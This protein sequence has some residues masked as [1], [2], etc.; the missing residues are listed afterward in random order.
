[1]VLQKNISIFNKFC[2]NIKPF[3]VSNKINILPCLNI[4]Y[5]HNDNLNNL[6][7]LKE[8]MHNKNLSYVDIDINN[9]WK[10]KHNFN[11]TNYMIFDFDK[12]NNI[13]DNYFE[14][15]ILY[16]IFKNIGGIIYL[17][18]NINVNQYMYTLSHYIFINNQKT[19]MEPILNYVL[20]HSTNNKINT[21]N[22][23]LLDYDL[24]VLNKLQIWP[25][26]EF[27]Y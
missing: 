8:I 16:D 6:D 27:V 15:N 3:F 18:K 13:F 24:I 2:G 7:F 23:I 14:L 20:H 10:T 4:I 12:F 5:I 9:Y 11:S 25:V 17:S 22:E 21:N 1:M 26:F 19:N